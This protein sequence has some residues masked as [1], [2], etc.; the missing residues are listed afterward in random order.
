MQQLIQAFLSRFINLQRSATR[1]QP[2]LV[3]ILQQLYAY[4]ATP[5]T[6]DGSIIMYM[7]FVNARKTVITRRRDIQSKSFAALHQ[8]CGLPDQSQT[9]AVPVSG[10]T[11]VCLMIM[12]LHSTRQA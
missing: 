11:L 4:Q 8:L 5:H 2:L 9:A 6:V 3:I 10:G 12:F 1:T 7:F